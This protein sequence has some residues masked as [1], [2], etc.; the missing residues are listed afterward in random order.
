M[1][2]TPEVLAEAKKLASENY[3]TWGQWVVECFSDAELRED[4]AEFDTLDDWVEIR[5]AVGEHHAEIEN[6][7]W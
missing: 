5:V 2:V 6:T 3:S 7:A 4:L 1:E